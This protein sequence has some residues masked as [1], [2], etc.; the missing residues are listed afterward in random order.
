M[1]G[2]ENDLSIKSKTIYETNKNFNPKFLMYFMEIK[3]NVYAIISIETLQIGW[4]KLNPLWKP[5]PDI[6]NKFKKK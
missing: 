1:F 5:H 3:K 4:L 6:K 2:G